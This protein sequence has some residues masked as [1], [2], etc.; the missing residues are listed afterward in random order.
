MA[1]AQVDLVIEQGSTFVQQFLWT[2]SAGQAAD[3]TGY[4]GRMQIRQTQAS[5]TT[6]ANLTSANGGITTGGTAGTVTINISATDTA[7][8]TFASAVYDLELVAPDTVTVTRLV[9]GSVTLSKEVT[10]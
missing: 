3:L 7:A 8:M 5:T 4:I 9:Q 2:N 1:A 6:I 10:R